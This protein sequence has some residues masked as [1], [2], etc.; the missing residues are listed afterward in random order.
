MPENQYNKSLS[1]LKTD[2]GKTKSDT[3]EAPSITLP[4]CG[5]IRGIDEKFS[6]NAVNVSAV[7]QYK[8]P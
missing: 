1:F 3:S 2:S 7:Y 4:K 6:V 5:T 8:K